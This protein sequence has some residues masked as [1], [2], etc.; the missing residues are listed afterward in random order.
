MTPNTPTPAEP[1]KPYGYAPGNY[2]KKCL[3]CDSIMRD[4][5]KSA[6]HCRPC[7]EEKRATSAAAAAPIPFKPETWPVDADGDTPTLCT[8]C[9]TPV[10]YGSRHTKCAPG[11][12][13]AEIAQPATPEPAAGVPH[14][15]REAYEA[16]FGS[17][18]MVTTS[19][20]TASRY[21]EGC[22]AVLLIRF[23]NDEA[24]ERAYKALRLL[25][26]AAGGLN[27]TR[28]PL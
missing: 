8:V 22:P 7:A 17:S 25:E 12:K 20:M 26:D 9:G 16:L 28:R 21:L 4:V 18:T 11:W 10:R 5:D 24:A 2:T 14:V 27:P 6:T 1:L 15:V 3:F 19:K 23:N 13:A